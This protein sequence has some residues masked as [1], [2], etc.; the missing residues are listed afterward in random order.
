LSALKEILGLAPDTKVIV[1]NGREE[2][3]HALRA[4]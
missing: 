3:A 1:V 4:I 2:R